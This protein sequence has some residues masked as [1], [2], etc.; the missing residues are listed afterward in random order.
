MSSVFEWIDANAILTWVALALLL[1]IC[2]A[3]TI[4]ALYISSA[5]YRRRHLAGATPPRVPVVGNNPDTDAAAST[6][7]PLGCRQSPQDSFDAD[8]GNRPR[9]GR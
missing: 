6:D 3:P 4:H 8:H 7:S 2:A 9:L 5:A 1:V